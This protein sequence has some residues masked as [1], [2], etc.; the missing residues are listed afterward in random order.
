M[1]SH[2][3]PIDYN[4]YRREAERLRRQTCREL[5]QKA[6]CALARMLSSKRKGGVATSFTPAQD[7]RFG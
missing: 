2:R 3:Q 7:S 1:I 4:H 5:T 6:L